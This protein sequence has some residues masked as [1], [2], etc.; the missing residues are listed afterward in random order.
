MLQMP[1]GKG[2]IMDFYELHIARQRCTDLINEAQNE[3]RIVASLPKTESTLS[4]LF[5][6]LAGLFTRRVNGTPKVTRPA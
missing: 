5:G 6:V 4:R 3:A 2:V 1:Y